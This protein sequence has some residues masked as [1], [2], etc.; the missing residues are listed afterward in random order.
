LLQ[1][2]AHQIRKFGEA[3]DG[4]T[5]ASWL[6][7]IMEEVG[8]AARAVQA[9]DKSNYVDE[10]VQVGALVLAALEDLHTH[11]PCKELPTLGE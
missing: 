11:R 10:L 8:E 3:N 9:N 5:P 6:V 2:R 4:R 1:E 7:I